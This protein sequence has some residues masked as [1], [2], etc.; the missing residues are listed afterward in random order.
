MN[1]EYLNKRFS[2]TSD[3]K[4]DTW[5]LMREERGRLLGDCEDYSL[6]VAFWLIARGSW[7]W[8]W[9]GV[10]CGDIKFHFVVTKQGNDGHCVLEYQGRMIDNVFRKWV[11]P[12][13]MKRRYKF[14]HVI[15]ITTIWFK[16]IKGKL[17]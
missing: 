7:K 15:W 12:D 16:M 2:Y 8:L 6:W 13:V 3:G 14:K 4:H 9:W 10:I 17:L 11:R 5:K 1:L